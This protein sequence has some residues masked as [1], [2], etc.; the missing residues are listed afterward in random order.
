MNASNTNYITRVT[1]KKNIT[2]NSF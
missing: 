2:F 1:K